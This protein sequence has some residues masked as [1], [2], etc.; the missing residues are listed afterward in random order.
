MTDLVRPM[1]A[2]SQ[3]HTRQHDKQTPRNLI[4]GP[5]SIIPGPQYWQVI[6]NLVK[7]ITDAIEPNRL[8]KEGESCD[9]AE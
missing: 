4:L 7:D 3:S 9:G 6:V 2:V 1:V 5:P 8:S